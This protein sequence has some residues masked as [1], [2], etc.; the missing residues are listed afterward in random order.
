MNCT[1]TA[2]TATLRVASVK[3]VEMGPD[4]PYGRSRA[5]VKARTYFSGARDGEYD[6]LGAFMAAQTGRPRAVM[7]PSGPDGESAPRDEWEAY[8]AA[9]V[10]DYRDRVRG[11]RSLLAD[12]LAAA[13]L[14]QQPATWN[15]KAGCGCGCSPAFVLGVTRGVNVFVSYEVIAAV[16]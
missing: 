10:L 3:V 4:H 1:K 11:Y 7:P 14:P 13:G 15:A 2:G 16:S 5:H 8:E 12:A 6:A 9:A